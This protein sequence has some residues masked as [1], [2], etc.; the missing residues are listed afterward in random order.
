[1]A[2][3]TRQFQ[4]GLTKGLCTA[5]I[6]LNGEKTLCVLP[7]IRNKLTMPSFLLLFSKV[8]EKLARQIQQDKEV[9]VSTL[10]RRT[11]SVP[12]LTRETVKT[13]KELGHSLALSELINDFGG[14][15]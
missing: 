3:P 7:V 15:T 13:P 9:E 5:D 11:V 12:V 1:M 4:E 8:L 2:R 10:R 14:V 6:I